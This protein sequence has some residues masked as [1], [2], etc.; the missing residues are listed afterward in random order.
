M[1]MTRL[2]EMRKEGIPWCGGERVSPQKDSSVSGLDSRY[3][4]SRVLQVHIT[5]LVLPTGAATPQSKHVVIRNTTRQDIVIK[6]KTDA[7]RAIRF[8]AEK[9]VVDSRKYV[10]VNM[11]FNERELSNSPKFQY[12]HLQLILD[13]PGQASLVD[14]IPIAIKANVDEDCTTGINIDADTNTANVFDDK[15][16][17]YALQLQEDNKSRC[18]ILAPIMGRLFPP[19]AQPASA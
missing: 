2:T 6:I 7:P 18:A 4:R 12:R 16:Y 3:Q 8:E 11:M 13:L 19:A 5:T 17:R 14:P 15:D 10:V 1:S 9:I